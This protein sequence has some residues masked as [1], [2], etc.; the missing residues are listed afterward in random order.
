MNYLVIFEFYFLLLELK[1]IRNAFKTI[2][3]TAG[4][5]VCKTRKIGLFV[6]LALALP[7]VKMG[8]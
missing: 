8:G 7:I 1:G 6:N 2:Q 4:D 3:T 5:S